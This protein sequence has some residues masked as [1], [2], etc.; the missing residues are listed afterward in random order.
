MATLAAIRVHMKLLHPLTHLIGAAGV[1]ALLFVLVTPAL[2][3][4]P[5]T[6]AGTCAKAG[7]EPK[8]EDKSFAILDVQPRELR[9]G[10]SLC[11]T[12]HNV[13]SAEAGTNAR[14][15][16]T[17]AEATW[18]AARK[19]R[20]A[21]LARQPAGA[22]ALPATAASNATTLET[23]AAA[24]RT[25]ARAELA[26]IDKPRKFFLYVNGVKSPL[27]AEAKPI[28]ASQQLSF[29]LSHSENAASDIGKFW[30]EAFAVKIDQGRIAARIGLGDGVAA[31]LYFAPEKDAPS[32][33]L[34]EPQ[35]R[36]TALFAF[37]AILWWLVR[38]CT[39]TGLL[40]DG[41]D[42]AA[43]YSLARVQMMFWFVLVATGFIYIWV[44]AGQWLNV[45]NSTAFTLLAIAGVAT[46]AAAAIDR[47][48]D[49]AAVPPKPS[50]GLL[51]DIAAD[52]NG[53]IQLQRIQMILWTV[54]LGLIFLWVFATRLELVSF[55]E[56][57]LALA[58]IVNGVYVGLKTQED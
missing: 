16:A 27:T 19:E 39:S 48:P 53:N 24:D 1:L 46:G 44:V 49:A 10:G 15:R 30:R 12:V 28:S 42:P 13:V 56:N 9:L 22:P 2:F 11:V 4:A 8:A 35:F 36:F 23:L 40:R 29:T 51:T 26:A 33:V 18:T 37:A 32:I 17:E 45:L 5:D 41:S 54:I 14:T 47:N 55:D 6:A 21:T 57:L 52:T 34:Y 58:G 3:R 50:R 31:P 43:T 38:L 7:V 25:E 20:L